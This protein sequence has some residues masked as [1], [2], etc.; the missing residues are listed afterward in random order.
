MHRPKAT[1]HQRRRF[2]V[3]ART[4]LLQTLLIPFLSGCGPSRID[5][6]AK[7]PVPTT[8]PTNIP[9][10]ATLGI[11]LLEADETSDGQLVTWQ[12]NFARTMRELGVFK[13]VQ[14]RYDGTTQVDVILR[15]TV[16]GAF[17]PGPGLGN[18]F[19]WFPGPLVF[20]HNWRGNHYVFD[21]ASELE[22]VD[23]ASGRVIGTYA[24]QTSHEM[25]HKS[26]NPGPI[27]GALS[28]IPGVVK[29][30]LSVSPSTKYRR[31]T[32]KAAY[33]D[34]WTTLA[35]KIANDRSAH[36]AD[37]SRA[38]AARCGEEVDAA[39]VVSQAFSAFLDCQTGL[40]DA[41]GTVSTEAGTARVY[42][43]EDH[44]TEILVIGDQ[45]VQWSVR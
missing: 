14:T 41:G 26:T 2:A 7:E 23:R 38:Q 45:I 22:L 42:H 3:A 6:L 4:L 17:Q 16:S 43:S 31:A 15:G 32:Y 28:V 34:L 13:R 30:G 8:L 33:R 39:P 36:Y 37:R 25:I 10:K 1:A 29:G 44:K 40:F 11:V 19:T 27:L 9:F 24:A 5:V 21:A 35:T 20:A 18:F 12:Q